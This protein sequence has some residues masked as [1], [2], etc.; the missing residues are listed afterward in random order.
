MSTRNNISGLGFLVSNIM[1]KHLSALRLHKTVEILTKEVEIVDFQSKCHS[2]GRFRFLPSSTLMVNNAW[3]QHFDIFLKCM[4]LPGFLFF[5]VHSIFFSWK[6]II[7]W[8]HL[9]LLDFWTTILSIRF[10]SFLE[11]PMPN[12]P[13]SRGLALMQYAN[14]SNVSISLHCFLWKRSSLHLSKCELPWFFIFYF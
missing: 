9:F 12:L 6:Y 5:I 13:H 3:H 14:R 4:L 7:T 10:H 11:F 8:T 1:P 2:K